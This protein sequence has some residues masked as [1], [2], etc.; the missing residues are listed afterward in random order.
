MNYNLAIECCFADLTAHGEITEVSGA[1]NQVV[2]GNT[3]INPTAH[4]A[5]GEAAFP[6][7]FSTVIQPLFEV[8]DNFIV[9]GFAGGMTTP[10]A[11]I[12]SGSTITGP[13]PL[14]T[15]GTVT[16]G[17]A[18]GGNELNS[19]T[20]TG[21]NLSV[22]TIYNGFSGTT[23]AGIGGSGFGG[24][25]SQWAA[26]LTSAQITASI[27]NGSGT[28]SPAGN[29]LTVTG[30]GVINLI[31]PAGAIVDG[32]TVTGQLT[33]SGGAI[34]TFSLSGSKS[35][36][37]GLVSVTVDNLPGGWLLPSGSTVTCPAATA[38]AELLRHD[39]RATGQRGGGQYHLFRQLL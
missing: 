2:H 33:G 13:T 8:S 5:S 21:S 4:D 3:V 29:V 19:C 24:T 27:D 14:I 11:S 30:N 12:A 37:P 10:T 32:V 9:G 31:S 18:G 25:N 1:V 36:A 15:L 38:F 22:A 35:L 17:A 34:G 26:Q 16:V 7:N 39:D 20:A 6:N 23:S 28:G